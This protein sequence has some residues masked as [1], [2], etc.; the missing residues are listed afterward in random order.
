MAFRHGLK[1]RG[2]SAK[3]TVG[4]WPAN[5]IH[6]GSDEVLEAF[7]QARGQIADASS[8][9]EKRKTQNVYGAMAR[10][11][12][13][14]TPRDVGG[15]AARFFYCAKASRSDRNDG[16]DFEAKPLLWSAGTQN[17]G[18]FQSEGTDKSA[19]NPHPSS[20]PS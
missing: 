6:D 20:R 11:N 9:S 12:D 8:S 14:A 16:L 7:P 4:R 15:S 13:G 5:V 1:D 19:K 3:P 10:G 17:P 18:S 2:R